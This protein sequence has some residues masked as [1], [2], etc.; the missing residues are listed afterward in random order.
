MKLGPDDPAPQPPPLPDEERRQEDDK[1]PDDGCRSNEEGP[2]WSRL[3]VCAGARR[4]R[5]A[6]AAVRHRAARRRSVPPT[7]VG[8]EAAKYRDVAESE[9]RRLPQQPREAARRRSGQ[10]R[11]REPRRPAAASAATWE[12]VLRKLAVRAMPPQ[13]AQH[14]GRA[15]VRR[16]HDVARR[17]ARPRVGRQEHAGPLRRPSAEPDRVRQRRSRS[18]RRSTSTSTSCCR[19]TA[20]DFGFDNIATSLKTSPLLLERYLTAAQRISTLAVGDTTRAAR[21]HGIPD[22]PRVHAERLHRR[23]AARHARRHRHPAHVFPAD[24][25]YKLS[26]RLV[27]GVEEGYAGVEGNDQPHTFVITVDGAEVFSTQIGGLKDHEVQARDMNEA[28][29]DHR[30]AHDRQGRA[31]RR[32][33][34]TSASRGAS[35]RSSARTSGSPRAATARKST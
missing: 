30:R 6:G 33:R 7:R 14:P 10:P 4:A 2:R 17:L 29:D 34:T 21:Q 16:V 20:R 26:G 9:L 25:E 35:G 31:S 23:P 1:K 8:G 19:A 12:R 27:R 24:G 22:Q 3:L 5:R 11:D 18:A 13:G 15:R 28:R 32:A